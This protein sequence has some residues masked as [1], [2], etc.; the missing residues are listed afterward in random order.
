MYRARSDE[1]WTAAYEAGEPADSVCERFDLGRSNFNRR[2]A[3]EGWRRADQTDPEPVDLAFD[4]CDDDLPD[5]DEADFADFAFRRMTVE[6]RRGRLQAALGWS[7]LRDAALRQIMAAEREADRL[8]A[9]RSRRARRDSAERLDDATHVSRSI[10]AHAQAVLAAARTDR[11]PA[12]ATTP[13]PAP[14]MDKL[15][16]LDSPKPQTRADRRRQA[17]LARKR[18]PP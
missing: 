18:G 14:E 13:P 12:P 6:A 2:K 5:M 11:A 15:D 9:A 17:A 10:Q 8:D 4:D 1:T 16:R 3:E 7:R